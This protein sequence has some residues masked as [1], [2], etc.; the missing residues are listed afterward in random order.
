VTVTD[1]AARTGAELLVVGSEE[2]AS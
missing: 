2:V 1:V